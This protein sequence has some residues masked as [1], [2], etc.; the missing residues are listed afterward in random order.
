MPVVMSWTSRDA[1]LLRQS[2]HMTNESFAEFLGVGVR[3]VASWRKRPEIIP[4]P[5][6]QDAL[7]TA[8]ERAPDRVKAKFALLLAEHGERTC[9]E[10]LGPGGTT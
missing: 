8:L 10:L 5:A 4:E 7:D 2:L 6:N 3:T 9:P 1:D